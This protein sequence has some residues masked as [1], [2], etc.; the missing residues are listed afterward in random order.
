MPAPVYNTI[1]PALIVIFLFGTKIKKIIFED[2][3]YVPSLLP[4]PGNLV[5][6]VT[7]SVFDSSLVFDFDELVTL[8]AEYTPDRG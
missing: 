8:T 2:F 1:K 7:D 3:T 6:G 5:S 4:F